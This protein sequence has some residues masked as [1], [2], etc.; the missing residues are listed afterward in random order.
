M[1]DPIVAK[2]R[3]EVEA[4]AIAAFALRRSIRGVSAASRVGY[5][6]PTR[7]CGRGRRKTG[8]ETKVDELSLTPRT[9]FRR[10]PPF[11]RERPESSQ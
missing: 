6:A 7:R 4:K 9:T 1:P 5:C 10:I 8:R 3:L 11:P 2:D